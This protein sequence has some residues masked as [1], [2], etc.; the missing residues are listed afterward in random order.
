MKTDNGTTLTLKENLQLSETS[1][2]VQ[3]VIDGHKKYETININGTYQLFDKSFMKSDSFKTFCERLVEPVTTFILSG[4]F[5]F[6]LSTNLSFKHLKKLI[7]CETAHLSRLS[8]NIYQD[9]A[10]ESIT[11]DKNLINLESSPSKID[12]NFAKPLL[13]CKSMKKLTFG[14]EIP[15]EVNAVNEIFAYLNYEYMRMDEVIF[16]CEPLPSMTD[17]GN[18]CWSIR[19][20]EMEFIRNDGSGKIIIKPLILR[21]Q[22][23][24]GQDV[25]EEGCLFKHPVIRSESV[26]ELSFNKFGTKCPEY[27]KSCFEG[28]PSVVR[29]STPLKCDERVLNLLSNSF[30]YLSECHLQFDFI[31]NESFEKF[32]KSLPKLLHVDVEIL[33]GPSDDECVRA[34]SNHLKSIEYLKVRCNKSRLTGSGLETIG[35]CFKQ[36]KDLAINCTETEADIRNLFQQLPDLQNIHLDKVTYKRNED[37]D[38]A[39]I[40]RRLIEQ[41][42]KA[43]R[44]EVTPL[45]TGDTLKLKTLPNEIW[46]K[47]F[48]YLNRNAQ[49]ACRKVCRLWFN[50]CGSNSNL[51]RTI[52]FSSSYLSRNANPVKIFIQTNFNYNRIVFDRNT[53]VARGEDLTELWERIGNPIEKIFFNGDEKSIINALKSGL[54]AKHLPKLSSLVFET[55]LS[56]NALLLENL[57][58]WIALLPQIRKLKFYSYIDSPNQRLRIPEVEMTSLEEFLI[59]DNSETILAS[60]SHLH[61]PNIKKLLCISGNE[62]NFRSLFRTNANFEQLRCLFVV[63]P[64]KWDDYEIELI[65][66]RCQNLECLGLCYRTSVYDIRKKF[67]NFDEILSTSTCLDVARKMFDGK[68]RELRELY[69]VIHSTF[70]RGSQM[71]CLSGNGFTVS[72]GFYP[73]FSGF[74]TSEIDYDKFSAQRTPLYQI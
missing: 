2:I 65:A 58:E 18:H 23:K 61:L 40:R 7:V 31:A 49:L 12:T 16:D 8:S 35:N 45:Y 52:D 9:Y 15:L 56:F 24:D 6:S 55:F 70:G 63:K 22:L 39:S 32:L 1:E 43:L 51:Y 64:V 59:R 42:F 20:V 73:A 47:I 27:H 3:S 41:D 10:F 46:E 36:L 17:Y 67:K 71:F 11:Y 13:Y 62:I 26:T 74:F 48:L 14:C 30:Q 25:C 38:E 4:S 66:K 34:I 69:F 19:K 21:D 68:L 50:I 57:P 60:L 29:I 72:K 44:Y 5:D 33:E 28:F 37:D 54:T 53:N